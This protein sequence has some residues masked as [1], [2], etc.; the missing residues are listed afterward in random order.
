MS[1]ARDW[2]CNLMVPSQ[3]HFHCITTE[4]PSFIHLLF[5]YFCLFRAVPAHMYVPRLGVKLEPQLPHPQP[6]KSCDMSMTC[7]TAHGNTRSLTHW[8]RPGIESAS[9][10]ILV[11]FL[12]CWTSTVT[13]LHSPPPF[14]FFFFLKKKK[15]LAT[16]CSC[17]KWD[18][19]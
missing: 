17:L 4:T 12:T 7:T 16:A 9:S 6:C 14:F 8:V 10:W 18:L 3:I 1:K 19:S 13:L 2:T 5:I 11:G 15:L